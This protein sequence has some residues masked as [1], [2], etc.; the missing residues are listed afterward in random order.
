MEITTIAKYHS[1]L[2][3]KTLSLH[4]PKRIFEPWTV[5]RWYGKRFP[6]YR[7]ILGPFKFP[8]LPDM[9]HGSTG[10]CSLLFLSRSTMAQTWNCSC[11]SCLL[12]LIM[13]IVAREKNKYE[14]FPP[15][16]GFPFCISRTTVKMFISF[17]TVYISY[18]T[19]EECRDGILDR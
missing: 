19:T 8:V 14:Q 10:S 7:E 13:L 9:F 15:I 16:W 3:E 4:C 6:Y 17:G 11:F 5:S 2:H 1:C 18:Y 12:S